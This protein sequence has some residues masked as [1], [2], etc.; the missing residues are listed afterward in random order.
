[1]GSVLVWALVGLAAGA[2]VNQIVPGRTAVGT[3][4]ALAAGLLGGLLGGAALA[5]LGAGADRN[6]VGALVAGAS[7]AAAVRA[8][9]RARDGRR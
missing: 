3:V 9:M 8:A 7:A 6:W 5:A 4:G 1:M 2:V